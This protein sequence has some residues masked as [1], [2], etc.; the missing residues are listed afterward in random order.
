[1]PGYEKLDANKKR[2]CCSNASKVAAKNKL[3]KIES[4]RLSINV[5]DKAGT[6]TKQL[7]L[8]FKPCETYTFEETYTFFK[9][10]KEKTKHVILNFKPCETYTL[11][12]TYNTFFNL[13]KTKN[14]ILKFKPCETYTLEETFTHFKLEKPEGIKKRSQT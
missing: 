13:E 12:E 6:K 8:N 1:M 11:E 14:H 7:I 2:R 5:Q 9:L 10:E 3:G 4:E